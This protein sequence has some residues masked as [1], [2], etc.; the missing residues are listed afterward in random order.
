MARRPKEERVRARSMGKVHRSSPGDVVD[1]VPDR[2]GGPAVVEIHELAVRGAGEHD[3]E[4]AG[5]VGEPDSE[6]AEGLGI[7]ED[8]GDGGL[9]AHEDGVE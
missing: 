7:M 6:L 1:L 4:A 9:G 5:E 3:A 2:C 8:V